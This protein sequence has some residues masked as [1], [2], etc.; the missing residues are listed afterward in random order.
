MAVSVDDRGQWGSKFGFIM[1]AAG[2]AVGLGNIWRFPYITGQNGGGAFVLIYIFCVVLIGV[3]LLFTEMG[4]GRYAG[5]STVG[6]FKKTKANK[7]WKIAPFMALS[8]SFFVLTY[9]AVIGGWAV[10]YIFTSLFD[11]DLSFSAFTQILLLSYRCL[12]YL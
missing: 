5:S 2:S 9:Y 10:G 12:A 7:F 1:A 11:I 8:V 4:L 6:A 3:P